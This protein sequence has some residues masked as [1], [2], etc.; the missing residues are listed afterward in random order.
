MA[1][2]RSPLLLRPVYCGLV[3]FS[4]LTLCRITS[5]H[6]QLDDKELARMYYDRG[7]ESFSQKDHQTAL[8]AFKKAYHLARLPGL[9]FNI[10]QCHRSLKQHREAVTAFRLY[11][12]K[13]PDVANRED[14]EKLIAEMES[15]IAREPKK[16][17]VEGPGAK[18]LPGPAPRPAPVPGSQPRTDL[19]P[20][21]PPPP[22]RARPSPFYKKWWFWSAVALAVGGASVGVYFAARPGSGDL[23]DSSLGVL[24]H[25]R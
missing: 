12:K 7:K 2:R 11:L 17:P 14:I 18:T 19:T 24:D 15:K 20:P 8:V 10:G 9:L 5:G 4:L 1:P 25:S 23:P 21:P 16:P 22:V 3:A 6:A 13:K